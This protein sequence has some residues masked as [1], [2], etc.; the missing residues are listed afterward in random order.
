[1]FRLITMSIAVLLV[2]AAPASAEGHDWKPRISVTGEGEA[3]VS[4]DMAVITLSVLREGE[5]AREAL[6][7]N[8]AAMTG[9]IDAL[10][11][12]GIEARDLQTSGL[13]ISPQYVYPRDDNDEERPRIVGY[14]VT[15]SLTVRV[16]DLAKVGEV[17]DEAVSLGVNQGGNIVFT[18]EDLSEALADARGRAVEDAVA[19]ARTLA[20][21]AGVSLGDVLRIS[22]SSVSAPPRPLGKV[23]RMEAAADASVPVEAGENTH[24]IQVDMVFELEQE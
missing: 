15:N 14:Q 16:R 6:D 11:G 17:L 4:P 9:V 1:M 23:M 7:E 5:T 10:K 22:E 3:R 2:A 8:N 19:K 18:N 24:T 13:S 12:R 20:E 21:A